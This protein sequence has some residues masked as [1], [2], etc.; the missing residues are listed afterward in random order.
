MTACISRTLMCHDLWDADHFPCVEREPNWAPQPELDASMKRV[1]SIFLVA[2]GRPCRTAG[3]A[4]QAPLT[5]PTKE[6]WSSRSSSLSSGTMLWRPTTG[7]EEDGSLPRCTSEAI[8]SSMPSNL[9]RSQAVMFRLVIQCWWTD[10][11]LRRIFGRGATVN[12]LSVELHPDELEVLT[13]NE[14]WLLIV[15]DPAITGARWWLSGHAVAPVWEYLHRSASRLSRRAASHLAA[16]TELRPGVTAWWTSKVVLSIRRLDKWNGRLACWPQN[17]DTFLRP[18][19]SGHGDMHHEYPPDEDLLS[20]S[21]PGTAGCSTRGKSRRW[22]ALRPPSTVRHPRHA[23]GF[24]GWSWSGI[25]CTEGWA[26]VFVGKWCPPRPRRC[27]WPDRCAADS[28]TVGQS[29]PGEPPT[30]SGW[31][32]LLSLFALQRV[33]SMASSSVG[34]STKGLLLRH[35]SLH[36]GANRRS[37]SI[38]H[39]TPS[40]SYLGWWSRFVLVL[41][42]LGFWT[43]VTDDPAILSSACRMVLT[44]FCRTLGSGP[45]TW[46]P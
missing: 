40:L 17:T 14:V 10:W 22:P 11:T 42:S 20:F 44:L 15:Y 41:L 13:W 21:E 23:G 24:D 35:G 19:A 2:R 25:W 32:S 1:I 38:K 27:W 4:H 34:A 36:I 37:Q 18:C 26:E 8:N 33:G 5:E 9:C 29:L 28:Y 43:K 39:G 12:C 46:G 45:R 7:P 31:K 6:L 30:L 3:D 16:L